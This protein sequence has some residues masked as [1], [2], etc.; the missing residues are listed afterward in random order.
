MT[1][2][3]RLRKNAE[4]QKVYKRGTSLANRYLV[5]FFMENR[6]DYSNV[7]FLASKKVGKS[8]ERNRARRL[9]KEAFRVYDKDLKEGFDMVLI[10]RVN[11]KDAT[12]K[13]V[14]KSMYGILKKSKLLK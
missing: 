9:M 8:V 2:T 3:N 5:L 7:G 6:Q 4:F 1:V 10:A 12:Y 11:I 14:E 13:D